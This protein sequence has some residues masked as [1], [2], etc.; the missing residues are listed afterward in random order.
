MSTK[1]ANID[2]F[3][4]D[5]STRFF[6]NGYKRAVRTIKEIMIT[7][8]GAEA[9]CCVAIPENWSTKGS[10]HQKVHLSSVDAALIALQLSEAYCVISRGLTTLKRK[11]IT[12]V[13]LTMKA[14]KEPL[15]NLENFKAT[16][17]LLTT[18]GS[19]VSFESHIGG[20]VVMLELQLPTLRE[21]QNL[22][23]KEGLHYDTINTILGEP[24]N[25]FY[26]TGFANVTHNITEVDVDLD[27][28]SVTAK[29]ES[30]FAERAAY[31]GMETL[32]G[33]GASPIDAM[34]VLSQLGQCYLYLL[35]GISRANSS[36]LWMRGMTF[37]RDNTPKSNGGL[38]SINVIRSE[39][40]LIEGAPWRC[41]NIEGVMG[42][43]RVFYGLGHALPN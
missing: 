32:I 14:G 42:D 11:A 40:I 22:I 30:A 37:S 28:A 4:G 15:E 8:S 24:T 36:T 41:V 1:F 3:L 38:A 7:A 31:Q 17:T 35:D 23:P 29:V 21:H 13:S 10:T 6:S 25:N 18:E 33:Q 16:T 20:M 9:M 27:A 12:I 34:V 2:D 19:V 26:G 39:Q 43:M 5:K